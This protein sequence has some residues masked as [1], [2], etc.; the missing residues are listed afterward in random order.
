[1][2]SSSSS[3]SSHETNPLLNNLRGGHTTTTTTTTAAAAHAADQLPFVRALP[4]LYILAPLTGV[5]LFL[6]G[7]LPPA[8]LARDLAVVAMVLSFPAIVAVYARNMPAVLDLMTYCL[9]ASLFIPLADFT[10]VKSV[11]SLAFTDTVA[12]P[13]VADQ[14][15]TM[16]LMW[17]MPA[18]LGTL[19]AL[20]LRD[21]ERAYAAASSSSPSSLSPS[22]W[23]WR[24]YAAAAAAV[25]GTLIASEFLLPWTRLW[26]ARN[27][28]QALGGGAFYTFVPE[29]CLG[30]WLLAGYD[31][32]AA[33]A[34]GRRHHAPSPSSSFSPLAA[35]LL[36]GLHVALLYGGVIALSYGVWEK[37]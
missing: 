37:L 9:C 6:I 20:A 31:L 17:S 24:P 11:G 25:G 28:K 14:P 16:L 29:L 5:Y 18:F 30:V 36:V 8:T 1:M 33:V 21:Y 22:S 26:E 15:V 7:L 2:P 34:A 27:V 32:A 19:P 35:K 13:R 3:S 23:S 4:L 12:I 10:L